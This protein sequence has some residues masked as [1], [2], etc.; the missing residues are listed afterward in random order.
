M[1]LGLFDLIPLGI[2]VLA[3]V[4]VMMLA[5]LNSFRTRIPFAKKRESAAQKSA[6]RE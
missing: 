3:D 1:V 5:V 2:A 6:C 4:G